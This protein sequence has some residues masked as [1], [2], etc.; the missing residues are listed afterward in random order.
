MRTRFFLPHGAKPSKRKHTTKLTGIKE[1]RTGHSEIIWKLKTKQNMN[2][3]VW[4]LR[5]EALCNSDRLMSPVVCSLLAGEARGRA[6]GME[7]GRSR[8]SPLHENPSPV[9]RRRSVRTKRRV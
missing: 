4:E 2:P 5:E 9:D 6:W 3:E 1:V 7:V 8:H